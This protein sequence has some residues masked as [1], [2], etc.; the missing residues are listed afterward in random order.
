MLNR[1][2]WNLLSTLLIKHWRKHISI[3]LIATI[4][5]TI[6]LSIFLTHTSIKSDIDRVLSSSSEL[7]VQNMKSANRVDIPISFIDNLYEID[8]IST[9]SQRVYGRYFFKETKEYFTIIGINLFDEQ[10]S[11]KMTKVLKNIDVKK[12]LLQDSMLVGKG[13]KKLFEENYYRDNYIFRNSDNS[14][15]VKIYDELPSELNIISSDIVIMDI[16]LAKKILEIK[17]DYCTDIVISVPNIDEI[18]SI[19]EKIIMNR[20]NIRVLEKSFLINRYKNIL[21]YKSS[22][23]ISIYLLLLISFM[24]LIFQKYSSLM[25][26]DKK[27]IKV[28]K[29]VGWSI[30][31]IIFFKTLESFIILVF[32]FLFSLILSFIYVYYFDAR[33]IQYIFLGNFNL[34]TTIDLVAEVDGGT[35]FT[36][37]IIFSSIFV[38][39]IIYPIW[40]L[41]SIDVGEKR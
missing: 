5:L 36:A 29:A 3:F 34:D 2:Y 23:L 8:G 30:K 41:A 31:D 11:S 14:Y 21:D 6:F 26:E 18:E 20:L 7:I 13:V 1:L 24:L 16:S 17:D 33:F 27:E 37:F 32:A 15:K 40:K 9:I 28:F 19:K 4:L 25:S 38:I 39:S 22:I 35:L 12:F 10:I